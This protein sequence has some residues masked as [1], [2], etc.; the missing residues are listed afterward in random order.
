MQSERTPLN[1]NMYCLFIYSYHFQLLISTMHPYYYWMGCDLF[2]KIVSVHR[3]MPAYMYIC[4][5][6]H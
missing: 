6:V 5:L 1:N 2:Q 3:I 4:H